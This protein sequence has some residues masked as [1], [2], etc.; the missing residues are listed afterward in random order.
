MDQPDV[1]A[2]LL[3]ATGG[4][5]AQKLQTRLIE[6]A[7]AT[8]DEAYASRLR[9]VAS[10]KRPLRTLL[11][12]PQWREAFGSRMRLLAE[13][14][15]LDEEQRRALDDAVEQARHVA[16]P[17]EDQAASDAADVMRRAILAQEAIREEELNGWTYVHDAGEKLDEP[18]VGDR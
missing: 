10:G 8:D 6:L 17:S 12:D 9:L 7:G 18:T 16:S 13:P 3:R 4:D 2:A 11:A 14:P 1:S 5:F 15:A